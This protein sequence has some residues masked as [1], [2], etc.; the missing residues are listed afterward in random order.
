M[1]FTLKKYGEVLTALGR[2]DYRFVSYNESQRTI[3]RHDVDR[4]AGGALRMA[5]LEAERG[6]K[7][8]YYFRV[9]RTFDV[10]AI[11]RI[12]S[13]GH[14]IGY[15]YECLDKAKG[16]LDK[17]IG[18]FE[19]ELA[20]FK[21]WGAKTICMHGNPLSKWDNRDMWKR[22][23]FKKYGIL[24]EAYLSVDFNKIPYFTDTGRAW[25]SEKFSVKDRTGAK[26]QKVRDT[27]ELI[28][29]ISRKGAK[30]Y[31]LT[32]PERWSDNPLAWARELV[33]QNAKNIVKRMIR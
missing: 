6:I 1:D 9:P 23:D 30:A 25:N 14:E 19:Q 10:Q 22:F 4:S 24:G 3:L 27:D 18:I 33:L 17:A 32:H 21:V 11:T 29:I 15:H 26:L 20:L 2:G 7:A 5:L 13:L 16:D 31:I 12:A 8:T 28:K